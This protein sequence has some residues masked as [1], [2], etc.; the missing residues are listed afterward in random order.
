[1]VKD[2]A[3]GNM[4]RLVQNSVYQFCVR[5]FEE[6]PLEKSRKFHICHCSGY[7]ESVLV[8]GNTI[9]HMHVVYLK[10]LMAERSELLHLLRLALLAPSLHRYSTNF[11]IT[12]TRSPI[13]LTVLMVSS[14]YVFAPRTW[15]GMTS[16]YATG[17]SV[18]D[19]S[20]TSIMVLDFPTGLSVGMLES[21]LSLWCL[22]IW[23]VTRTH[24]TMV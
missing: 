17:R 8:Y 11:M 12:F 20:C 4:S 19:L 3:H 15:T 16:W 10:G 24:I 1:M 7:F 6:Q 2:P 14:I 5:P 21:S 18:A 22:Q 13:S 23:S 9:G